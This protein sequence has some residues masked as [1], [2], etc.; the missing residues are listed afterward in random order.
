MTDASALLAA[1]RARPKDDA[2]RLVYADWLDE[3]GDPDRARL[4]RAQVA[5]ARPAA[6]PEDETSALARLRHEEPFLRKEVAGRLT[7]S[8]PI[9]LVTW[10]RG[11]VR[12]V[13]ARCDDFV[14]VAG[15]LFRAEPLIAT[16]RLTDRGPGRAGDGKAVWAIGGS[17]RLC[18]L[19]PGLFDA[20]PGPVSRQSPDGAL[21]V[22][23]FETRRSATMSLSGA[24]VAFGRAQAGLSEPT[25]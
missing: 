15:D 7:F 2:P 3:H 22:R 18:E 25:R 12:V 8:R 24:C 9:T 16:V 17:N 14:P 5:V 21:R 20:F 11:F 19:P 4:I 23:E 6:S 13:E 10:D 1:I